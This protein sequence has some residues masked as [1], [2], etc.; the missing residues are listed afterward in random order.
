M[1][2]LRILAL[3]GAFLTVSAFHS[4]TVSPK[5]GLLRGATSGICK[6]ILRHT[7]A[8]KIIRKMSDEPIFEEEEPPK[9]KAKQV[10]KI[11]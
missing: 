4:A 6:P 1:S 8:A 5:V 3:L 9:P 11:F 7:N 2:H 10:F